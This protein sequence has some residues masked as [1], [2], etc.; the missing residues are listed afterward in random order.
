MNSFWTPHSMQICGLHIKCWINLLFLLR[1]F[2]GSSESSLLGKYSLFILKNT[3]FYTSIVYIWTLDVVGLCST[4][5]ESVNEFKI[6]SP[7]EIAKDLLNRSL[8]SQ[9]WFES[10]CFYFTLNLYLTIYPI[11]LRAKGKYLDFVMQT[12]V[13]LSPL[14]FTVLS[15]SVRQRT[16]D[17]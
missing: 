8:T 11:F 14:Y 17:A 12:S 7:C 15:G 4:W 13:I 6:T 2:C 1:T 16:T 5:H 3:C 9:D 10:K